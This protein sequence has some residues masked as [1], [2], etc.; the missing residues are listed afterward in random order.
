MKQYS[1][2]DY[3]F[4]SSAFFEERAIVLGKLGHHEEALAIYVHVLRENRMAEEYVYCI[5]IKWLMAFKLEIIE[6]F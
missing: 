3:H 4:T 6:C 1:L 2:T 5:S